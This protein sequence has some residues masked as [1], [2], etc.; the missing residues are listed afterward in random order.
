M[1]LAA[2]NFRLAY[3]EVNISPNYKAL[4]RFCYIPQ[5][6]QHSIEYSKCYIFPSVCS[7]Y[8]FPSVSF[9]SKTRRDFISL[10]LQLP[11]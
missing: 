6:S 10:C 1:F 4:K 11:V 7:N 8:I 5:F 3:G 9:L 2:Y